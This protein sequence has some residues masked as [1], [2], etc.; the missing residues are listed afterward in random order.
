MA[1]ALGLAER[2]WF[3]PYRYRALSPPPTAPYPAGVFEAAR[4]TLL[5]TIAEVARYRAEWPRFGGR[6]EPPTPRFDQDWFPGIDAAILYGL[7]RA[8]RPGRIVEVGSGHSTRFAAR[9]VLDEGLGTRIVAID[10][11]PRADIGRLAPTVELRP[12]PAQQ[13]G[14]DVFG[15]LAAGD[16]LLIDSSH[17][18]MP[19][20]DVDFLF[21]RVLPLLPAG[22]L[23]HI[24]DIFLPDPYPAD[25]DWRGYNEQNAVAG[26]IAGGGYGV[27]AASRFMA[28][29]MAGDV[30]AGFAGL[31]PSPPGARP[32]SLWLE[33]RAPAA[34]NRI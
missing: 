16:F 25:W 23:V 32:A 3:I 27:V 13:A 22:V 10:P 9:A 31:P 26:L 21:N 14:L 6:P 15:T 1:Q 12:M 8:R 30:A 28:T 29:R 7:A 5:A 17:V 4:P 18:L 20:S 2:G 11:A 19:G 34:I 33:K 24:H